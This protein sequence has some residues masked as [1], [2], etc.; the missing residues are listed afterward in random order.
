MKPKEAS[1]C[2]SC[3]QLL[4][5]DTPMSWGPFSVWVAKGKSW[6]N[7]TEIP[8]TPQQLSMFDLLIRRQGRIV[9]YWYAENHIIG[10]DEIDLNHLKVI[11]CMI[12]KKLGNTRAIE[13]V[14]GQGYRLREPDEQI[15]R[16]AS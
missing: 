3:G 5:D 7:K 14:Y 1:T 6:Y 11:V 8:L 12:R 9:P 15:V 4:Q 10:N 13:A 16:D 2:D